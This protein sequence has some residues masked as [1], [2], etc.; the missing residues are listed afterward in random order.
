MHSNFFSNKSFVE[1]HD[2]KP[3]KQLE[4]LLLPVEK[5]LI[6]QCAPTINIQSTLRSASDLCKKYFTAV[7]SGNNGNSYTVC[8]QSDVYIYI[9]IYVHTYCSQYRDACRANEIKLLTQERMPRAKEIFC[10][11]VPQ[12]RQPWS[13]VF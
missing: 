6:E 8:T 10:L 11:H 13:K 1:K 7:L 9:Y 2:K 3:L 4:M 12:V 5:K